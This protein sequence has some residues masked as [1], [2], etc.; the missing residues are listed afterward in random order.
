MSFDNT[1]F[2]DEEGFVELKFI[3]KFASLK[4]EEI[5]SDANLRNAITEGKITKEIILDTE[6]TQLV[7]AAHKYPCVSEQLYKHFGFVG[8]PLLYPFTVF[9]HQVKAL[10]F[11]RERES[12]DFYGIRGGILCLKMG[13]GKT[14]TALL[15]TLITKVPKIELEEKEP[16]E[17]M[18]CLV[19]CS[20]TVLYEWKTNSQKFFD[21]GIKLLI[22]H[23]DEMG[24]SFDHVT[25]GQIL[26]NDVV[27]TTY[28]TCITV[29]RKRKYDDIVC[30]RA[31]EGLLRDKVIEIETRD[32]V[33]VDRP[34]I[35]GPAVIYNTPWKRVI[36]DESQRF[37]N[38]KTYTYKAIMAIYGRYKWCLSGTPIRNYQT[39]IWAQLRFMGYTGVK[40]AIDWAKKGSSIYK[41][42]S[43]EKIVLRMDYED[44]EIKLP[45]KIEH[46]RP[47]QLEGKELEIYNMIL[48]TAV[49]LYDRVLA[50]LCSFACILA[51]FTRL[52]QV[53]IAPYLI[54]AKSKRSKKKVEE[55]DEID[56]VLKLLREQGIS[57]ELGEWL[58]NI[59][60]T[61]GIYST[62][63][64][65]I[66]K[67][68]EVLE[69]GTKIVIFSMFSSC[70]DLLATAI[71]KRIPGFEYVQID[72]STTGNERELLLE[73][74]KT[75]EKTRAILL[76]YRVGA[77]GLN[78]T[79]A[80]A[81]ICI[82]PWWTDAVHNQAKARC[83]RVGQTKDVNVYNIVIANTI[84]TRILEIC[85]EKNKMAANYLDG[86]NFK[87]GGG[88][89]DIY[90]LGRILGVRL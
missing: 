16:W 36:C 25:R 30:T 76:S 61:A 81:C 49:K 3:K 48:G 11:M 26:S 70:L 45:P 19:I 28:D 68:L 87:I 35:T 32:I 82:E 62:K 67:T 75:N 69:P 55:A 4:L 20:K 80:T 72:G 22:L 83:W 33:G 63:I 37:A 60:G 5:V 56:E 31:T 79:E 65:A 42:Q 17:N 88:K 43:L 44:A 38:P 18:P 47:I 84:E 21:N 77:E 10:T 41:E 40:T 51:I 50:K 85:A 6:F 86:T 8:A 9:P 74:F 14:L 52:R 59:N 66:I 71:D 24:K 46:H 7:R 53:C 39:D 89:I 12:H 54:T 78:L 64:T 27:V 73:K 13:M 2:T 29:C 58:H 15:Y 90:T 34:E 1:Y 57:S 23:K